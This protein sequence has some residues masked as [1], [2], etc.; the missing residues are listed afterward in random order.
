MTRQATVPRWLAIVLLALLW[1]GSMLPIWRFVVQEAWPQLFEVGWHHI[2]MRQW[3]EWLAVGQS[4]GWDHSFFNGY[5]TYHFY[6]PLPALGWMLLDAIL[7]SHTAYIL[8]TVLPIPGLLASA[9]WLSRTWQ[10]GKSSALMFA[11]SLAISLIL[12]DRFGGKF[13]GAGYFAT[14]Y[15][16]FAH[17]WGMAL[18]L[19]SLAAVN[20]AIGATDRRSQC[21]WAIGAGALLAATCL[22]HP[23]P[24]LLGGMGMLTLLR[25]TT[26][27]TLTTVGTVSLGLSAWWWT[28]AVKQAWMAGFND[29]G[30]MPWVSI[31]NMPTMMLLP[32]AAWGTM[33]LSRKISKRQVLYPALFLTVAPLL[34]RAAAGLS[35]T[36]LDVAGRSLTGWK[37]AVP[38]LAGWAVLDWTLDRTSRSEISR[39]VAATV[40]TAV[41][42]SVL[43]VLPTKILKPFYYQKTFDA[44][45]VDNNDPSP[46]CDTVLA[47]YRNMPPSTFFTPHGAGTW[48][49]VPDCRLWIMTGR[50][51]TL[52]GDQHRDV[53]GLLAES[54]PTYHFH[55]PALINASDHSILHRRSDRPL[56]SAPAD[57]DKAAAQMMT[58]GVD[59][60]QNTEKWVESSVAS[61]EWWTELPDLGDGM[62]M[63]YLYSPPDQWPSQWRSDLDLSHGEWEDWSLNEFES[64]TSPD[65]VSI[66]V[67]GTPP[68]GVSEPVLWTVRPDWSDDRAVTF[69]A[70]QVGYFY[71]PVSFHPNWQ[72]DTPGDGPYRAGPNQMVV[73]AA[74][75]GEVKLVFTA[76]PWERA[77]QATTAVTLIVS[78][79]AWVLVGRRR[80]PATAPSGK[81]TA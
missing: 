27:R 25:R 23:L 21:R 72:L 55:Q 19:C 63:W 9:Y 14:L 46:D 70:S 31:F 60:Y 49:P 51:A 8:I 26:I 80:Y 11:G 37:W 67:H 30:R 73:Y 48:N 68:V 40:L 18:V 58:L 62:K 57:W 16:I 59:F 45:V 65:N 33:R 17:T 7:P 20:R 44:V 79:A 66:P 41:C 29:W 69:E 61:S 24:A 77:G 2:P 5:P 15:G 38:T 6:F 75:A 47:P 50:A 22:S 35:D 43:V 4:I 74:E 36:M 56:I 64:W 54:T 12:V 71:I 81:D 1:V 52:F 34:L 76:G 78:V 53:Y 28:P 39:P 13:D 3:P 32:L 42:F 10:L